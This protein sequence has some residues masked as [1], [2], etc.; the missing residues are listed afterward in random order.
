MTLL[1]P[2]V[3][4]ITLLNMYKIKTEAKNCVSDPACQLVDWMFSKWS[5]SSSSLGVT[6]SLK[7][8]TVSLM[9]KCATCLA[10]G[11]LIPS[12]KRYW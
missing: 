8:D 7:R 12:P 9:N 1:Q 6:F 10:M 2:V 11:A 4:L 5:V 3:G